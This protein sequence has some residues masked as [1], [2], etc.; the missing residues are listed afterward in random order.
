MSFGMF[1]NRQGSDF[2]ELYRPAW[3]NKPLVG[4]SW[5]SKKAK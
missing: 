1:K 4:G 2:V 3:D 5:L